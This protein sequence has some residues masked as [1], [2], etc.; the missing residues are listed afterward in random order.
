VVYSYK[1]RVFYTEC[2]TI[3]AI[4][5]VELIS[6]CSKYK[7]VQFQF[8][9]NQK[10][11]FLTTANIIRDQSSLKYSQ[12][13]DFTAVVQAFGLSNRNFDIYTLDKSVAVAQRN[14]TNKE[15][16]F[17]TE[18][19]F[20][21]TYDLMFGDNVKANLLRDFL[22]ASMLFLFFLIF[23]ISKKMI[24]K[25]FLISFFKKISHKLNT[26]PD[27]EAIAQKDVKRSS[28]LHVPASAPSYELARLS[29]LP[30]DINYYHTIG[31]TGCP[32]YPQYPV[33]YDNP[34]KSVIDISSDS[35]KEHCSYCPRIFSNKQGL[36]SHMRTQHKNVIKPA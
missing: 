26:D 21:D 29:Y 3:N 18:N 12:P 15:I 24:I 16:D 28:S 13:C 22:F 34:S 27:V 32:R 35:K 11:G 30:P 1:G 25:K 20:F 36:S 31:S 19:V 2:T 7:L 5:I 4:E 10:E 17:D 9:H 8:K 14:E 33:N 23:A 6:K